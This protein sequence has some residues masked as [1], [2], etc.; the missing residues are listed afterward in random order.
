MSKFSLTSLKF[1]RTIHQKSQLNRYPQIYVLLST[2]KMRLSL[3]H[4]LIF[5]WNTHVPMILKF[6]NFQTNLC[7]EQEK[8]RRT[9]SIL[10]IKCASRTITIYEVAKHLLFM[11]TMVP[12]KTKH[13]YVNFAKCCPVSLVRRHEPSVFGRA[14]MKHSM[15]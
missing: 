7:E 6:F 9:Q 8:N 14:I 2:I 13:L 12:Q 15:L 10:S 11:R 4:A 3:N 1:H 5:F